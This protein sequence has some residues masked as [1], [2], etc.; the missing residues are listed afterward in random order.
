ME[1][2]VKVLSEV[3]HLQSPHSLCAPCHF[4]LASLERVKQK[5]MGLNNVSH[6]CRYRYSMRT[7]YLMKR[8]FHSAPGT[9]VARLF[10]CSQGI[11][12]LSMENLTAQ[13]ES[14]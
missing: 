14:S 2:R 10:L 12:R 7:E 9:W 1:S 3:V 5:V 13:E 11:K 4:F 6:S 8:I